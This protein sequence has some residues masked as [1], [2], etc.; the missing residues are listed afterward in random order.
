MRKNLAALFLA[1][2]FAG[3]AQ[4]NDVWHCPDGEYAR[5]AIISGEVETWP[6]FSPGPGMRVQKQ[7]PK[8]ALMGHAKL[9]E[10]KNGIAAV[11][12]YYSHIGY[13]ITMVTRIE[14]KHKIKGKAYWRKE[15]IESHAKDDP[16]NPLMEVCMIDKD[17]LAH[18]STECGLIISTD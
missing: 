13:V 12:Q 17:G 14:S 5:K 15:Y 2:S 9:F 18:M 6:N 8:T 10:G 11:C 4:A 3:T 16:E 1:L 7:H